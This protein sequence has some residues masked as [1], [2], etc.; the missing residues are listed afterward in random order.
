MAHDFFPADEVLRGVQ[1]ERVALAWQRTALALIAVAAGV[2]RYG[3]TLPK[4]SAFI[5]LT[6][7]AAISCVIIAL[8]LNRNRYRVTRDQMLRREFP[9]PPAKQML[10]MSLCIALVGAVALLGAFATYLGG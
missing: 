9:V 1:P 7:A 3:V 5:W 8:V 6:G 10:L 4:L 2:M